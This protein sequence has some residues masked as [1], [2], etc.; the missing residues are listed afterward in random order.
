MRRQVSGAAAQRPE[1][2]MIH[3]SLY[4]SISASEPVITG[5]FGGKRQGLFCGKKTAE[6]KYSMRRLLS[7]TVEAWENLS[8][9]SLFRKLACNNRS[10]AL[11]WKE[12]WDTQQH[13]RRHRHRHTHKHAC[14]HT[15]THT[16]TY[17]HTH[18]HKMSGSSSPG[19]Q[20][21]IWIYAHCLQWYRS[22]SQCV[23]PC[24]YTYN[25]LIRKKMKQA[26]M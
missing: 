23:R 13:T 6:I 5:H 11:L 17:A 25:N 15:H 21:H 4:K 2:T 19:D 7:C 8:C 20:R 26:R 1:S 14:T 24:V 16:Q 12:T 10:R 9:R 22:H 18:T 3:H